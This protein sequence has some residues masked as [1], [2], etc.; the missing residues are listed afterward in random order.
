MEVFFV[1][2][3]ADASRQRREGNQPGAT[4]RVLR[5]TRCVR[6]EGA[7]CPCALSGRIAIKYPETRG[8]APDWAPSALSAPKDMKEDE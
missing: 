5:Q 1:P 6:P 4:P 7:E 3:A 8:V 2:N